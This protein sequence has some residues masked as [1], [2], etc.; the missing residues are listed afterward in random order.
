MKSKGNY[1]KATRYLLKVNHIV[2]DVNLP[3]YGEYGKQVLASATPVDSGETANSWSYVVKRDR[4]TIQLHFINTN[5]NDGCPIAIIYQYG[6]ATGTGGWVEG[7]DYI[8][9]A[10][11]P[12]FD[13]II[14]E[15]EKEVT[16]L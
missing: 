12:V 11:Q 15:I 1:K 14:S 7:A 13:K 8:N 4:D 2:N 10:I 3:L 5:T 6:H 16:R 9:P